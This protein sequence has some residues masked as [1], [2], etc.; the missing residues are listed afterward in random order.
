LKRVNHDTALSG[1][2][3]WTGEGVVRKLGECYRGVRGVEISLPTT[4]A[5]A[6]N[7]AATK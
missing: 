1:C 3:A 7:S 6:D 5:V 2:G 4:T